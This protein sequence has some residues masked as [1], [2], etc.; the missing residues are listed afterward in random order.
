ML[1][2]VHVTYHIREILIRYAEIE[3]QN[4]CRNKTSFG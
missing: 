3:R 1:R 2:R 4:V